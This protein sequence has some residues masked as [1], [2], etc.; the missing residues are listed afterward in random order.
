METFGILGEGLCI[1]EGFTDQGRDEVWKAWEVESP[2]YWPVLALF[3][4][5][6]VV[7][8]SRSQCGMM[9]GGLVAAC[10]RID[11]LMHACQPSST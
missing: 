7:A 2:L 4:G 1:F 9:V 10:K 11:L 5:G 8:C 3:G 6:V